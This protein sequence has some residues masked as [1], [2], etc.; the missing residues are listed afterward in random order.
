MN[1]AS[2][3]LKLPQGVDIFF[4]RLHD[5]SVALGTD[6]IMMWVETKI[7]EFLVK[8]FY[9]SLASRREEPFPHG[10]VWNSW[11]LVRVGFFAWA[12]ILT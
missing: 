10:T 4:G 5:Y 12:K 6:D 1:W 11:A 2:N 3:T 7:N 8:F 9:S